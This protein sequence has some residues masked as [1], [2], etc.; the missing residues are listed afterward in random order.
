M[1][2]TINHIVLFLSCFLLIPATQSCEENVQVLAAPEF[3]PVVYCLLDPQDSIQTVRV[4]R[5]FQDRSRQSDWENK[6]DGYLDDTLKLV[7]LE[8]VGDQA[9][10]KTW[11]FTCGT[12]L[13]QP[14]DSVFASTYLFTTTFRPEYSSDYQLYVYFPEIKTM[15]SS[16]ITTLGKVQLIDPSF[17]PGRKVVIDPTQPYV[18]RWSGAEGTSY[19]QGIFHINYLEEEAGQITGKTILMPM[20]IVLQ[21]ND[22]AVF[23]QNV[24]GMHLLQTLRDQI[25]A[26]EGVRRKITALDFSFYYGGTEIAI[27]A[28]S[29]MNPKGP[30]GMVLDFSNLDNARGIFSSISTVQVNG[31]SLSNSSVDTISKHILTK[32]LNFLSSHEEF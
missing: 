25:P 15:V 5:V 27:F 29:G 11:E 18:I 1:I 10:H 6:Y 24:S 20:N 9:V 21:Y 31:L 8:Q 23:S 4:S 13:R 30:E 12:Q 17:V 2:K 26:R 19:Y 7:Y 16:K 28:N 14:D 32:P 3:I 22:A